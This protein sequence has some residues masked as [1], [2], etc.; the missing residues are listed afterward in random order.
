MAL[1]KEIGGLK[2]ATCRSVRLTWLACAVFCG[3]VCCGA[4]TG[5][6]AYGTEQVQ[7]TYVLGPGDQVSVSALDVEELGKEPYRIAM[8]GTLTLPF[9]GSVRANGLT[10]EEMADAIR[11]RLSRYVKDPDVTVNLLEMRSQP[12][13][14]LGEV[15]NPGVVQLMGQKS[16][17]EVLSLAGG[18]NPDAGNA[19]RITREKQ[20]GEIPLAEAELDDTGDFWIAEVNVK[21]IMDGSSPGKNIAVK[22]N[23][24]ITVPKGE[25]VYVLGAVKKSGGFVLGSREKVT[26]LQA[27]AM[28][29]GLDRF[30][31]TGNAKIV[32][33]TGGGNKPTEIHVDLKRLLEGKGIDIALADNDILFVPIS[34]TRQ[35]VSRTLDAGI[36]IGT[37]IAIWRP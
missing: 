21:E 25:M 10:V 6:P 19:I 28:A 4:Q 35:A 12:V 33:K 20:W 16:L 13:S 27:L 31:S 15:R 22:P 26:V 2:S 7:S 32:R 37:G 23:D 34:G 14:V 24:V 11:G 18:L 1:N 36:N 30:A 9:A 5:Q 29:E 17:F 8:D 3:A